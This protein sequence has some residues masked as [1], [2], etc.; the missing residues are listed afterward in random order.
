[1]TGDEQGEPVSVSEAA[2]RLGRSV[3]T[4]RSA[5]RRG[6]L[7]GIKGNDGSWLVY[8]PIGDR[9]SEPE[10]SAVAVLEHELEQARDSAETWRRQAEDGRVAVAEL[11]ART[12]LLE[13]AL[14][15][16]QERADRLEA[17]LRRPWWRKLIGR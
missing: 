17:D 7:R 3:D 14:R 15:R 10:P 12:E 16:E 5:L 2:R 1:M 4:I 13:H 6:S 9:Q 8:L 11:R